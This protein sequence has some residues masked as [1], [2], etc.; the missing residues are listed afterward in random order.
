[1]TKKTTTGEL[2]HFYGNFPGFV[3][4]D[5]IAGEEVPIKVLDGLKQEYL[6]GITSM[7]AEISQGTIEVTDGIGESELM[8]ILQAASGDWSDPAT[9][10]RI[11]EVD[12]KVRKRE[13]D[14]D[15]LGDYVG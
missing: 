7:I 12:C 2:T 11:Y 8:E 13:I 9:M 15:V 4:P 5:Y 10:R 6:D 14:P 3:I 1:M